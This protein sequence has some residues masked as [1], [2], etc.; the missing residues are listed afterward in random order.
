LRVLE[1]R[2]VEP[3]PSARQRHLHVMCKVME[4]PASFP[5]RP[6]I[7]RKRPLGPLRASDRVRR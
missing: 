5:R 1:P 2:R 3:Y 6:G 4:T 7:A